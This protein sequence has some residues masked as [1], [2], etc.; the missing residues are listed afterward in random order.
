MVSAE[1]FARMELLISQHTKR[2]AKYKVRGDA[3]HRPFGGCN[4][5]LFGDFL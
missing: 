4:I 2:R 5:F 1:L 3:T